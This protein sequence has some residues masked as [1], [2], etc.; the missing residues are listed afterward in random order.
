[1]GFFNNYP[2]TDFHELNLDWIIQKIKTLEKNLN[3]F[4][5]LHKIV[6]GGIWDIRKNY[7]PWT[8]VQNTDGTGYISVLPVGPGVDI[9]DKTYWKPV[10]NYQELYNDFSDRITSLEKS[11]VY[12]R[13]DEILEFNFGKVEDKKIIFT[14]DSHTYNSETE[15]T[16]TH[17]Q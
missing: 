7:H 6:W 17:A 10:A 12:F 3:D 8:I 1:M 4:E 14:S 5:I 9:S 11:P 16:G 2:Y 15:T 13:E